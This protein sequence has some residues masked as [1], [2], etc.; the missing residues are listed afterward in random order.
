MEKI[1]TLFIIPFLVF[2]QVDYDTEIQPILDAKCTS[3]HQGSATYFGG[4]LY[5]NNPGLLIYIYMKT[6]EEKRKLT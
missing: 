4:L 3:C 5:Q 6:E 2:C 1:I